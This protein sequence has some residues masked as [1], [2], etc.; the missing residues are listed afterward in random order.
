MEELELIPQP[1]LGKGKRG[2]IR[3]GHFVEG[4]EWSG[5]LQLQGLNFFNPIFLFIQ[6]GEEAMH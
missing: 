1:G 5:F 3:L 2:R 4:L 6:L